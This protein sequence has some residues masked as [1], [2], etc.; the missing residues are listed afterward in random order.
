MG[1]CAS[2]AIISWFGQHLECNCS[3]NSEGFI[4]QDH[5]GNNKGLKH[6]I[7]PHVENDIY[8]PADIDKALFLFDSPYDIIPSLFRRKI[9]AAHAFAISGIRPTHNNNFDDF[10][11]L[12]VDSFHFSQQFGNWTNPDIKRTYPRLIVRSSSIWDHLDA[13]GEFLG[14]PPS[15]MSGFPPKK[16]RASSFDALAESQRN[17]LGRIYGQIHNKINSYP[18]VSLIR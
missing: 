10:I 11:K 7:Q 3:H 1:G 12:E 4:N 5:T 16:T 14:L 17:G 2:T 8:L 6:R 13:V 18:V 15:I 9:A